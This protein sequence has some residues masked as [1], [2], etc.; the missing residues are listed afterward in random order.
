MEL[1]TGT[2]EIWLAV[3]KAAELLDLDKRNVRINIS[4]GKYISQKVKGN[5]GEQYQLLL[6]SLPTDAQVKYFKSL[7]EGNK[8][9]SGTADPGCSKHLGSGNSAYRAESYGNKGDE[10]IKNA[11][12]IPH[13]FRRAG[14][15]NFVAT[16]GA[17][18]GNEA[19]VFSE[20]G[21][22]RPGTGDGTDRRSGGGF[23]SGEQLQLEGTTGMS[24]G[25]MD[26][27][28]VEEPGLMGKID[29]AMMDR[30]IEMELYSLMPKWQR[31]YI[32]KLLP[33][34]KAAEGLKG[35]EL[36]KFLDATR[37]GV[38]TCVGLKGLSYGNFM[39]LKKEFEDNGISGLVPG[40][41]KRAGAN[42]IDDESFN[43]FKDLYLKEGRPTLDSCWYGAKGYYIKN[44]LGEIP[45]DFPS[46]I[47]F[48]RRLENEV[49]KAAI[50]LA[51]HGD[52]WY[53]KHYANYANRN[54]DEIGI[55]E[56]WVSDHR[57]LDQAAI[58]HLPDLT[59][60]DI[61]LFLKYFSR[62]NR[63]TSAPVFPWITVWRDF[64]SGKWMGWNIHLE[65]P[66][67]DFIFQAFYD[68]CNRYGVPKE[69]YID[70][71]KDY[72]CKDFA[73]GRTRR[74]KSD[75]DTAKANSLCA[76]LGI[77]IH[78]ATPYGAQ[79]KPIERD[80]RIWKEWLDKQMPGYRG[81][82]HV[83]RPEKLKKEIKQGKIVDFEELA[84]LAE[85]FVQNVLEKYPSFGKNMLGRSREEVF[86][87]GFKSLLRVT[88]D[89]LKMCCM[90]TSGDL[91][92]RRNGI[93]LSQRYNLYY[94]AEWM[95]PLK[96][97]S[98]Y[99]RRDINNYEEA[100]VFDAKSNEYLGKGQLNALDTAALARDPLTKR[101]VQ[102]VI[103]VKAREKKI[104]KGYQ[105][106]NEIQPYEI[107]ENFAMGIAAGAKGNGAGAAAGAGLS[108]IT[109][110]T[111]M[112]DVV[113]KENEFKRTGTYDI[114]EIVPKGS[115]KQNLIMFES[116]IEK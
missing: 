100:W 91:T 46:A 85:Y 43:H 44:N 33:V 93:T 31:E 113:S 67:S 98:V 38:D 90:R 80:F 11:S 73:G 99:L 45:E 59:K 108:N 69:I 105:P 39:K 34:M 21:A 42:K 112:D 35:K 26:A 111:D 83:E 92:I 70:N 37:A 13:N 101:Q 72:R 78:Y 57:Q 25:T 27:V 109:L 5:G 12:P 10:R 115:E 49:P 23:G 47:T 86:N 22:G 66:N 16:S 68:G 65:D 30:E 20:I 53:N 106:L 60:K 6:S 55:G 75:V 8:T 61:K 95:N 64:K 114:K 74:I 81:G 89:A 94:W 7:I 51:R 77:V 103:A 28:A 88:S 15:G 104:L 3:R 41:G 54:Y 107:V 76:M 79:T 48:M 9:M 36:M 62:D 110:K 71:G 2:Q 1:Q 63:K 58:V 40:Y 96:G 24:L 82:N 18:G 84:E 29:P 32:D 56:V 4:K 50:E 97:R 87:L 14:E 19:G 102:D 52:M 116:D 17:R